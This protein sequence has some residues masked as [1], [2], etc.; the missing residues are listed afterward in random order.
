LS[1]RE[2]TRIESESDIVSYQG[3]SDTSDSKKTIEFKSHTSFLFKYSLR[4]TC[5]NVAGKIRFAGTT[6]YPRIVRTIIVQKRSCAWCWNTSE[7]V[8]ANR[9]GTSESVNASNSTSHNSSE[10]SKID[11]FTVPHIAL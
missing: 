3:R 1:W 10:L 9:N 8:R 2:S 5:S 7:F 4:K 6:G 11:Y